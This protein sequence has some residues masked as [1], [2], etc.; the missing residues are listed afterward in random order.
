[1]C[2]RRPD[3]EVADVGDCELPEVQSLTTTVLEIPTEDTESDGTF[4]WSS[5]C[6]VVVEARAGG[7]TGLGYT[8][9]APAAAAVVQHLLE[10]VVVGRSV[11]SVSAAWHAMYDALRNV[12]APGIGATAVSA[13][14]VALWDLKAR[15][16]EVPLAVALDCGAPAVPVYG[17]GGF[18][19]FDDDRLAEQLGSW[20]QAGMRAVKMKVGRDPARDPHRVGVAR[21]AVGTDV[22]LMVDANGAYQPQEALRLAEPFASEGVTWFEEPVSSDHV[23]ELRFLR[24]RLPGGMELAAGEYGWSPWAYDA[25]LAAPAVDVLQADVTRCGGFTGFKDVCQRAARAHLPVSAHCAPQLS[26]YAAAA[27]SPE[28]R[29]VEWFADHARLE[30]MIFDGTVGPTQGRLPVPA[31]RIGHGLTLKR[32]D[33]DR[34]RR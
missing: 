16:L 5:T 28:A 29:D 2:G 9:G 17:S 7:L 13:V 33:V 26:L 27:S 12:G 14:D 25:L 31:D 8:Y 21:A 10:P 19:S 15:T 3:R 1:M 22:R 32:P 11:G 18:T 34:W 4:A 6:A 24:M 30:P 20:A 23:D